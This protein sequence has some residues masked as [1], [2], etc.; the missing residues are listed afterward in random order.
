MI[1]WTCVKQLDFA[2]LRAPK[3]GYAARFLLAEGLDCS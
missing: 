3:A 2:D 1:A